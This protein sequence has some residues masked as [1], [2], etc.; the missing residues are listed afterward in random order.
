MGIHN[1]RK[2]AGEKIG[3]NIF[4]FNSAGD[5]EIH[6]WA[7]TLATINPKTAVL[8]PG[9]LGWPGEAADKEFFASQEFKNAVLTPDTFTG[10]TVVYYAENNRV[11]KGR[12]EVFGYPNLTE[13]G[14][15][16]H[17]NTTFKTPGAAYRDIV[18]E[19]YIGMTWA[20]RNFKDA[21][22]D[23]GSKAW[24]LVCDC[25]TLAYTLVLG[26]V[27]VDEMRVKK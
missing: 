5:I 7:L 16:M 14:F 3:R 4:K 8:K 26:L 11:L 1:L 18:S 27:P 10:G 23:L 6:S 19:N 24:H 25:G 12:C 9:S 20:W 13:A 2:L 21:L 15:F 17:D 22:R